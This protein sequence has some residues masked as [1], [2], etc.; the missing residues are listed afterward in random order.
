[1]K[2]TQSRFRLLAA[3]A[4]LVP[5]TFSSLGI[6]VA[7]DKGGID[8][9]VTI[10]ETSTSKQ[11]FKVTDAQFRWGL[12][13]ESTSGAFAP[14]TCNF[15]SAGVA[16]DA[17][18]SREWAKKD[19]FYAQKSGQVRIE[20]PNA[21]GK[22]VV[23]SWENKCLDKDGRKVGTSFNE[24]GTGAQ[25][26]IEGGTG[27][28]NSGKKTASIKW[29]GSFTSALYNGMTYWSAT[30]PELTVANGKGS[31]TA[32]L[33]GYG[34]DREDTSRWSPLAPQR[35]V[36]ATLPSVNLGDKGIVTDP[37]YKEVP[38]ED[39]GSPQVRT[40]NTWGAFPQAFVDFQEKSGQGSYWYSTG[41]SRDIAKIS[42]TLYISYTPENPVLAVPPPGESISDSGLTGSDSGS[43]IDPPTDEENSVLDKFGTSVGDRSVLDSGLTPGVLEP[44]ETALS[45]DP[46]STL[47]ASAT[48]SAVGAA[49]WLGGSLIPEAIELARDYQDWLLWSVAGLLGLTA[50][51]WV[52]FRKGWLA[53]PFKLQK[54][55]K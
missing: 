53:L 16:G 29:K 55:N 4:L 41:G 51:S 17:K 24:P 7:A 49:N 26:V 38:V 8:V 10:P 32:T 54:T 43:F 30:D 22:W 27:V 40:G 33:S 48:T 18:F 19:G 5:L 25:I 50:L 6:A 23:D 34:T 1:M 37:A 9:S 42:S 20:K 36:I 47:L 11:E 3:S 21:A 52:G 39:T 28:I 45:S 15:L 44:E 14:G 46:L 12:N 31:L 35:V 13:K 2:L